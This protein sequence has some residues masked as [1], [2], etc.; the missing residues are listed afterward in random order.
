MSELRVGA[1]I[2]GVGVLSNCVLEDTGISDS[3]LEE[4]NNVMDTKSYRRIR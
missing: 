1:A 2:V 4:A 3:H